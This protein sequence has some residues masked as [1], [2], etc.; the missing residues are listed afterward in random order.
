MNPINF[1]SRRPD[2]KGYSTL[3]YSFFYYIY[4]YN[5][6]I[7]FKPK[8]RFIKEKIFIIKNKIKSLYKIRLTLINK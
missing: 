6:N 7:Y 1:L 5:L 2:Y 8:D 3:G 4:K